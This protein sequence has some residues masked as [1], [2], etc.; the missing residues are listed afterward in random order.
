MLPGENKIPVLFLSSHTGPPWSILNELATNAIK[1]GLPLHLSGTHDTNSMF[2]LFPITVHIP[3][4]QLDTLYC[5]GYLTHM[6]SEGDISRLIEVITA[7]VAA[8]QIILF[9]SYAHRTMKPDSD[10]DIIILVDDSLSNLREIV[11]LIYR[12]IYS[13]ID[14]PCDILVEH[15]STFRE[16]SVLPTIERAIAREGKV[17]YAA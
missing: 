11:Q 2:L 15:E 16:R 6:I 12:N 10:I 14:I 13:V 7:N 9:G 8:K 4:W 5:R 17:L 3:P 1:G